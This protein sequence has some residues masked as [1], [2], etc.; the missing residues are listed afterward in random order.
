MTAIFITATGTDVGK[1]F[2][3]RGLIRALRARGQPVDALKPL[4]T[5]FVPD[6]AEGSDSGLLLA[7]LGRP[8]SPDE[9]ARVSPWCFAAPLSPDMAARRE[10]RTIDFPAV[11]DFCR[12]AIA[13]TPGTLLIEGVG[14]IMVP[15]G[16]QHTVLDWMTELGL[17]LVVVA[18]SYLGSISHTLTA[19]DVLDRRRLKIVTLVVSETSGSPVPLEE[20]REVFA[21]FAGNT[22]VVALPRLASAKTPH[23][24]FEQIASRF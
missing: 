18:G 10:N 23:P 16:H 1:T 14:G 6:E 15:L 22:E 20:T 4:V 12:D 8:V 3:A 19:L 11:V 2:V 5:G 7:A 21:Q 17:P 24:V 13:A 9:I